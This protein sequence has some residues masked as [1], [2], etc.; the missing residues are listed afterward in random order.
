MSLLEALDVSL[1]CSDSF[2]LKDISFE[3]SQKGVYAFLGKSGSGKTVL[4]ELLAGLREPDD[5]V[6]I[7]NDLALYE[8]EKQTAKIKRKIGY[9]PQKC[10]FDADDNVFE[11]LDLVGRAK[12]IDPDKRYRQIKEALELTGLFEMQAARVG[13]LSLSQRKRLAIAASLLGNPDV[14]IMDEPFQYMDKEQASGVKSIIE[15]LRKRKVILMFTSRHADLD[16]ISDN[17][18]FL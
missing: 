5:G 1:V 12:K 11:T 10:F 9:V 16:Q 17:I 18:A 4:A 3:I 13:D 6:I 14:I 2:E 8:K 7:Y 15:I